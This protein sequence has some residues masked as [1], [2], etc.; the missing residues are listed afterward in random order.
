MSDLSLLLMIGVVFVFVLFIFIVVNRDRI[1][2]INQLKKVSAI[3]F[4]RADGEERRLAEMVRAFRKNSER[5]VISNV[6]Y[7]P[8]PDG[9]IFILDIE[10]DGE[11]D[12]LAAQNS[13]VL[14]ESHFVNMPR[15]SIYP[16]V[17][18]PGWIGNLT[19]QLFEKVYG[20]L[21]NLIE[22][23]DNHSFEERYVV[24]GDEEEK[25]RNILSDQLM[26]RINGFMNLVIDFNQNTFLI[27]QIQTDYQKTDQKS[28]PYLITTAINLHAWLSEIKAER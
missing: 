24:I 21:G 16:K 10:A 9:N 2:K 18:L 8:F 1:Q 14:V 6:F 28:T 5:V 3:G 26:D 25:I 19:D 22:G 20:T 27:N 12:T 23:W 13:A 7:K 17:Q 11:G 15:F 4:V